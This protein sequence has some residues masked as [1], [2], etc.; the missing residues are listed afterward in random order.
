MSGMT[1]SQGIDYYI[2]KVW[3]NIKACT[4]LACGTEFDIF[5]DTMGKSFCPTGKLREG[6]N[7]KNFGGQITNA[8]DKTYEASKSKGGCWKI[9][10][11]AFTSIP[12]DITKFWKE[13][14]DAAASAGKTGL[15]KFWTQFKSASK[16]LTKRM[17]LVGTLM[18]VAFELPNIFKAT[19]DEGCVAGAIETGKAAGKI[20]ISTMFGAIGGALTPF[21]PLAGSMVGYFIGGLASE[22]ILGKSY[23]AKQEKLTKETTQTN[24]ANNNSQNAAN[25]FNTTSMLNTSDMTNLFGQTPMNKDD[26]QRLEMAYKNYAFNNMDPSVLPQSIN[27]IA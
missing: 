12:D 10:K 5:T 23:S 27:T 4:A 2:P 1:V 8:L 14:T 9:L 11:D 24:N 16:V 19:K 26:L 25:P 3:K 18:M 7:F 17:P 22:F 21:C 6:V 20:G 15:S 13:G